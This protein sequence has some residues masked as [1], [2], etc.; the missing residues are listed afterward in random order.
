MPNI[1]FYK[2]ALKTFNYTTVDFCNIKN[3][4]IK[5]IKRFYQENDFLFFSR[6]LSHCCA[7][8]AIIDL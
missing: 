8:I 5:K 7:F 6:L 2:C 4:L 1:L 3:R